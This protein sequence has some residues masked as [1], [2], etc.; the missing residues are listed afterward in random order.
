M[1][2][3]TTALGGAALA[4]LLIL[5]AAASAQRSPYDTN[6]TP[7]ERAQTDALNSAAANDARNSADEI[8][9]T[10]TANQADYDRARAD[11]ENRM[12]NYDA[13]RAAYNR[14]RARYL[15]DRSYYGRRWD[16]F[17]GYNRFRDVS[18]F[19]Q[20]RLMGLQVS[21]R[22]GTFIGRVR[23]VDTNSYGRVTRVAV[24]TSRDR[25]AWIDADDLRYDPS[26]GM[27]MTVLSRGQI[28]DM[29]RMRY[30]RF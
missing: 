30:P 23:D 8:D 3:R 21:T 15:Y 5:A 7:A 11:Y 13:E 16:V 4:G 29:A 1:T 28:N 22:G 18:S 19:S 17:Y 20:S 12:D 27:V 26:T 6:P 2:L 9:N 24:S 14:D 25:V 10:N